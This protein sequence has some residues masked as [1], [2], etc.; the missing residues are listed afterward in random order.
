MLPNHTTGEQKK[1]NIYKSL[2]NQT[3][4]ENETNS[5]QNI[6]REGMML[7]SSKMQYTYLTPVLATLC[8]EVCTLQTTFIP[9][10][11]PDFIADDIT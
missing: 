8:F 1:E 10:D 2:K 6:W 11:K 3:V 9:E 4:K 7:L 5:A